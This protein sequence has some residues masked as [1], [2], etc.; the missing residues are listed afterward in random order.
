VLPKGGFWRWTSESGSGW[1][2]DSLQRKRRF[3]TARTWM[4]LDFVGPEL[5]KSEWREVKNTK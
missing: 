1:T 5:I 2:E 3:Q 4:Q